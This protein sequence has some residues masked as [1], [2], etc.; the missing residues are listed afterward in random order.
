MPPL[1]DMISQGAWNG[2]EVDIVIFFAVLSIPAALGLALIAI[3]WMR[4]PR[5][6][7]PEQED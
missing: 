4:M 7:Y 6:H 5:P 1:V 3:V 2:G